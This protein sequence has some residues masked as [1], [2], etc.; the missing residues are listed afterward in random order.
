[1]VSSRKNNWHAASGLSRSV[2]RGGGHGELMGARWLEPKASC[3]SRRGLWKFW[4]LGN[5]LGWIVVFVQDSL[6]ISFLSLPRER[7]RERPIRR[8]RADALLMVAA[9]T[10]QPV[11]AASFDMRNNGCRGGRTSRVQAVGMLAA[12][13]PQR[14]YRIVGQEPTA[15]AR[16]RGGQGWLRAVRI[17]KPLVEGHEQM[18]A[19]ELL[20]AI[21]KL[22]QCKLPHTISNT[23]Q[24]G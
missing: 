4:I 15:C 10:V 20:V 11:T 12:R 14:V 17:R 22:D 7:C 3:G 5:G 24:A 16:S 23:R 21:R 18:H 2:R 19:A 6:T 9:V 8:A 1:M 13:F